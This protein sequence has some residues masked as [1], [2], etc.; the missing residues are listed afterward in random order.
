MLYCGHIPH[1]WLH[2]KHT[3]YVVGG[4][5]FGRSYIVMPVYRFQE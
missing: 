4:T 5:V 1:R 2:A 3:S